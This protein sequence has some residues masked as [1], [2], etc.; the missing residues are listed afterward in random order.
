MN[1][2]SREMTEGVV[3]DY[4]PNQ[5]LDNYS[6]KPNA[7]DL[8]LKDGKE[9]SF[10]E[11]GNSYT[12]FSILTPSVGEELSGQLTSY[13]NAQ[14]LPTYY[15]KNNIP[16]DEQNPNYLS[17]N[18]ADIKSWYEATD[19][20]QAMSEEQKAQDTIYVALWAYGQMEDLDCQAQTIGGFNDTILLAQP[21]MQLEVDDPLSVDDT[22]QLVT[23]QVR[24][25]LGDSIQYKFL[26]GDIST[27]F[28]VEE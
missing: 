15:Y 27:R 22:A 2:P 6:L 17:E 24:W 8:Q 5:I 26:S 25:T 11:D 3:Q 14:L 13:L 21:T 4:Q 28:A 1:Y 10:V 16:E 19:D 7:I 18:F 20:V 23:D 9:S 12:G